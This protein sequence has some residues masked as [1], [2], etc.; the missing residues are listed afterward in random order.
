[1]NAGR[2]WLVRLVL[3]VFAASMVR[4]S[5]ASADDH[6]DGLCR[7]FAG[8][9]DLADAGFTADDVAVL[10]GCQQD[11]HGDWFWPLDSRDSRLTAPSLTDDERR[12]TSVLASH[13]LSQRTGFLAVLKSMPDQLN[14][15]SSARP[16]FMTSLN[17]F[18]AD[19][20][21][22]GWG[23]RPE[24]QAGTGVKATA[25]VYTPILVDFL[26][27]PNHLDLANYVAWWSA[28]RVAAMPPSVNQMNPLARSGF[29]EAMGF[30]RA[31]WPWEMGRSF[32]IDEYLDWALAN[33]SIPTQAPLTPTSVSS[34]GIGPGE[35][36]LIIR[37]EAQ[38]GTL[39]VGACFEIT[40]T[41]GPK[42]LDNTPVRRGVV[43][44]ERIP[45]S[46]A[47]PGMVVLT[48]VPGHYL[49]TETK[50]P[51]GY[52]ANSEVKDFWLDPGREAVVTFVH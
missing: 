33:G 19:A 6:R 17:E 11:A 27:D 7:D 50:A 37:A 15:A 34:G 1:V 39:L 10:S 24:Y 4:A 42:E 26:T 14:P 46:P 40:E 51:S 2:R 35:T 23:V 9:A 32:S 22:A 12:Q 31:P 28:R 16:S 3:V 41:T 30:Y 47:T 45:D 36:W 13:I 18:T 48:A 21:S 38:D 8:S 44:D 52:E 5:P 29:I 20:I 43:C 49:V 25:E